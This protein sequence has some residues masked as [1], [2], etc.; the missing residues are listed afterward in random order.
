[1]QLGQKV[2]TYCLVIVG[3][4]GEIL[5]IIGYRGHLF[6]GERVTVLGGGNK[7]VETGVGLS[8]G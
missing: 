2:I 1:M 4:D 7:M 6:R 5:K 3:K 8:G